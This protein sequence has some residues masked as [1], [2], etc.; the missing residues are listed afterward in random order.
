MLDVTPHCMAGPA[1]RQ[2]LG[3]FAARSDRGTL[4]ANDARGSSV[5]QT[6]AHIEERNV[7][8]KAR[9]GKVSDNQPWVQ[10]WMGGKELA[11][12]D[13]VASR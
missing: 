12:G 3:K 2:C 4:E 13:L 10:G 6:L 1:Q 7:Q 11:R 5:R 9:P 8:L